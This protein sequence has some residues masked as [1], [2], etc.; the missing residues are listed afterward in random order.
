MIPA[1][2][3][4]NSTII[5]IVVVGSTSIAVDAVSKVVAGT[6]HASVGIGCR[7]IVKVSRSRAL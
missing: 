5:S 2:I 1:R 7:V 4:C 3:V 6:V